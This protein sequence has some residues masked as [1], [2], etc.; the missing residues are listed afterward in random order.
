MKRNY[1]LLFF[2]LLSCGSFAQLGYIA[3]YNKNMADS[4]DG[5][6]IRISQYRVKGT[7]YLLGEAFPGSIK[8]KGGG[9][10]TGKVLYDLYKQ[11]AG[12]AV[13]REIY[14]SGGAVEEFDIKLSEKYGGDILV[15]KSTNVFGNT[16][17]KS[18]FNIIEEGAKVSFLKIFRIRLVP[19]PSNQMD[20]DLRAF[21]QYFD[22]YLYVKG[23][24]NLSKIKLKSKDIISEVGDEEFIKTQI[25]N[26]DL[27]V[28]KEEDMIKL[29]KAI[30]N[31]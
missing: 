22:Y 28:S 6:Y 20:K 3:L 11:K 24:N 15:F 19:D 4:W 8:Y 23:T 25:K 9:S 12:L 14:E 30:N 29:I 18:Y 27:D 13:N 17:L 21:E 2:L 7:P 5:E 16:D 31:K 10:D 1:L 26:A